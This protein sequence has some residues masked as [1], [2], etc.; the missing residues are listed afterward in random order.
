MP[1]FRIHSP[2]SFSSL[3]RSEFFTQIKYGMK[4]EAI[5]TP[6]I[7]RTDENLKHLSARDRECYFENEFKLKFYKK[8]SRENCESECFTNFTLK[9]CNCTSL[10]QPYNPSKEIFHCFDVSPYYT[11]ARVVRTSLLNSKN[12]SFEQNCSCYATCDS[13]SY[14]VNLITENH[15]GNDSTIVVRMNMDEIVLYRRYQQFT[16]SDVISYVGGLLGWLK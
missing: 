12:F 1:S 6:E 15:D 4:V 16:A 13:I 5:V 9:V 7:I 2:D 8:Y 11:C 14:K 10:D 3:T